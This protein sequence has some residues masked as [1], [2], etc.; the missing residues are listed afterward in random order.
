LTERCLE[1]WQELELGDVVDVVADQ[2]LNL[3]A[4]RALQRREAANVKRLQQ[5]GS[6]KPLY[7]NLHHRPSV[8]VWSPNATRTPQDQR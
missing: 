4:V 1:R 8:A 7:R 3:T 2:A 6:V 5:A